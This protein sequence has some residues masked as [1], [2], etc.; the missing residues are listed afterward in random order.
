MGNKFNICLAIL[1]IIAGILGTIL[2]IKSIIHPGEVT[3][4]MTVL[5]FFFMVFGFILGIKGLYKIKKH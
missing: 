1:Q 4:T 3:I 2:F 5:A